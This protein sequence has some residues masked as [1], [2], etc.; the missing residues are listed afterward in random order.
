MRNGFVLSVVV[1]LVLAGCSASSGVQ[2]PAGLNNIAGQ[3]GVAPNSADTFRFAVLADR[4]GGQEPGTWARAIAEVNLLR[5][6]F[7]VSVGDFIPGYSEDPAKVR[8]MWDEFH[9]ENKGIAAPFFYCPG[10]HDVLA[11][12]GRRAYTALHGASG[13]TYY[14]FDYRGCHFIVLDTTPWAEQKGSPV[15]AEELAWLEKDLSRARLSRHVFILEHHPV[16]SGPTWKRIRAMLDPDK[17]TIFAGHTHVMA[18]GAEDG[19]PVHVLAVTAARVGKPDREA[20]KFQMYAYVTVDAGRP[21]V[22]LVALGNVLP[23]DYVDRLAL[24]SAPLAAD[25]YITPVTAAGGRS[26]F[27]LANRSTL[28]VSYKFRWTGEAPWTDAKLDW[29]PRTLAP[30]ADCSMFLD[31]KPAPKA[32]PPVLELQYSF[33]SNGPRSGARKLT[34]P[35]VKEMTA[36]PGRPVIADGAF[37]A[38]W[39]AISACTTQPSAAATQGDLDGSMR[40]C[41]GYDERNLYVAL[42]VTDGRIVTEG[43][44]PWERDGVEVFWDP[45]SADQTDCRFALPAHQLLAP[46]PAD[47]AK[48][49]VSANPKDE[50]LA[51]AVTPKITRR[52]GGYIMELAIP[53]ESIGP[54]FKPGPGK[55]LRMDFYADD[56]D[57]PKGDVHVQ[58][59]SGT[60]ESSRTTANY[61][62]V[63][64]K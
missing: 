5:P 4:N 56:K 3:E 64:F 57:D 62:I 16:I 24:K 35:V 39:T 31:V 42:D 28:S 30:G 50:K 43:K 2:T 20:G 48:L 6:D 53:L 12:E 37:A 46:V 41:V 27:H 60:H 51:P 47:G 32:A 9:A 58:S 59:I 54:G 8:A 33:T 19:V 11:A 45:R 1:C 23:H 13:K 44:E 25:A 17:T 52:A 14:S 49:E 15:A 55:T 21:T 61:V 34:L 63:R 10:N 40:T 29:T 22:A 36:A 38:E 7:V 26:I 18:Y